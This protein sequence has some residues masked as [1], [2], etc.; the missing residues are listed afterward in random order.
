VQTEFPSCIL[1]QGKRGKGEEKGRSRQKQEKSSFR[2]INPSAGFWGVGREKREKSRRMKG[3]KF[4]R[5]MTTHLLHQ[6]QL[7]KQ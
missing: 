5:R 4:D 3:T 2:K 1:G 6:Q 7:T